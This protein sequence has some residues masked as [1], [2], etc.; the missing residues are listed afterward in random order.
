ME[1]KT[2]KDCCNQISPNKIINVMLLKEN[3]NM[4]DGLEFKL[5]WRGKR[6]E[7]TKDSVLGL[8]VSHTIKVSDEVYIYTEKKD[9]TAYEV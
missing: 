9:T 7:L 3:P 4:P 2:V 8:K 5:R 6:K 1:N